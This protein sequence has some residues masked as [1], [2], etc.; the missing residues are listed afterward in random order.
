[1]KVQNLIIV[2]KKPEGGG[3]SV[4]YPRQPRIFIFFLC[5]FPDPFRLES[6]YLD[7]YLF[8]KRTTLEAETRKIRRIIATSQV[9]L[10]ET[11][12]QQSARQLAIYSTYYLRPHPL[13]NKGAGTHGTP[14]FQ[15]RRARPFT[16]RKA[17]KVWGKCGVNHDTKLPQNVKQNHSA[18]CSALTVR[19][20][21]GE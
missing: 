14:P 16:K 15:S 8:G 6:F 17:K 3:A 20:Y 4:R 13:S 2:M 9:L 10:V 7:H 21:L 18:Y 19:F 11:S 12:A 1:M 5:F